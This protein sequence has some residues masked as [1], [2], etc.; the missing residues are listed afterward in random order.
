[1]LKKNGTNAIKNERAIIMTTICRLYVAQCETPE[2]FYVG[3]TLRI[4]YMRDRE[5]RER[6]F[7]AKWTRQHGYKGMLTC[8]LVDPAHA[9]HLEDDMTKYLMS[10]YGPNAVR[11]GNFLHENWLPRE[12][13]YGSPADVLKLRTGTVSK[14][15]SELRSLI[16][17]FSAVCGLENPDHLYADPL[18]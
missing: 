2:H 6:T 14:F 12:F 10:V 9:I 11:G 4:P 16:D 17:R 8:D 5:H 18:P 7:G 1:M 3:T 15:R 13:R